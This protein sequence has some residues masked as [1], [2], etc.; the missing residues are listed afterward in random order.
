MYL[1][2]RSGVRR[3][4]ESYAPRDKARLYITYAN[5]G[6]YIY[7][8]PMEVMRDDFVEELDEGS[9]RCLSI[10]EYAKDA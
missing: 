8:F 3:L 9:Q 4:V 10:P 2:D 6:T 1:K 5:S 7:A